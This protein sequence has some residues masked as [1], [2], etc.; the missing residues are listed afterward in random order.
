MTDQNKVTQADREAAD[1][2]IDEN[3]RENARDKTPTAVQEFK[4]TFLDGILHERA[5]AE[6]L[7]KALNV[8]ASWAE[9]ETVTGKFDE[10]SSAQLARNA[11]KVWRGG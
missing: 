4:D 5:R 7:L 9:G 11:L 2:W 10:P 8:I 1:N 6:V 3:M